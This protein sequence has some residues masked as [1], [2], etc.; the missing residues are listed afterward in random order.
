[1]SGAVPGSRWRAFFEEGGDSLAQVVGREGQRELRAQELE[2]VV[3][4]H[5]PLAVHR[6]VAELHQQ[7]AL[8]GEAAGPVGDGGVELLGR[9]RLVGEAEGDRVRRAHPVTEKHHLVDFLARNVAVD[10][11]HDH[12]REGADVDLGGAEGGTLL[13]D[14]EVAGEGEAEAAGEHVPVRRAERGLAEPR[15]QPEE[16][17]EEV[18]GK[19][20]LDQGSVGGE[21]AEVGARAEDLVAGTGE[22]DRSDLLG[23]TRHF[24]RRDDLG[25]HSPGEHVALL[26]VVERHGGHTA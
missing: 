19:V 17:E 6:V 10:E 11:R 25:E 18:G 16:F 8:R 7:R 14:H 5:V 13:G 3:D 26:G 1:V 24:H 2:R 23:V 12:V 15:H 9:D 21:A 4:R 20:L 22:D